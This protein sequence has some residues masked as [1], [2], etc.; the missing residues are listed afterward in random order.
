MLNERIEQTIRH[1]Y[2]SLLLLQEASRS[3]PALKPYLFPLLH[4]VVGHHLKSGD[5]YYLNVPVQEDGAILVFADDEGIQRILAETAALLAL[6]ERPAIPAQL[7]ARKATRESTWSKYFVEPRYREKV[8]A[9]QPFFRALALALIASDA[10]GSALRRTHLPIT[11]W[12]QS[13]FPQAPLTAEELEKTIIKGRIAD[14]ARRESKPFSP[15]HLQVAAQKL[16]SRAVVVSPCGSGKTLAAYMW[17]KKQ[18]ER[19]EARRV[20]FLYPTR[21]TATEGFRDYVSWGLEDS[22]LMHGTSDFDLQGMSFN[23][24][25]PPEGNSRNSGRHR[26][27]FRPE[28]ALYAL[29]YWNRRYISATVDAFLSF[30]A[31]RY[32]ADCVLPLL[33]DSVLVVDEVHALD[34]RMFRHLRRFLEEC[35]LPVL[36]MTAT[37]PPRRRQVFDALGIPVDDGGEEAKHAASRPRYDIELS[38]DQSMDSHLKA[39]LSGD[40]RRLLL[41]RNRVAAC[42]ET[43]QRVQ[44]LIDEIDPSV[45]MLVYHSRF[46]LKDRQQRHEEVIDKFK[47]PER[48]LILVSTQVCQM[49]LDLDAE[50]LFTELAPFPDLVQR[51]G[52]ANRHGRIDRADVVI[53]PPE[54]ARPYDVKDLEEAET[55]LRDLPCPQDTSQLHLAE[56]MDRAGAGDV[57]DQQT[58]PLFDSLPK[59]ESQPYREIQEFTT[60]ALLDCDVQEYLAL[61]KSRRPGLIVPVPRYETK[62]PDNSKLKFLRIASGDKYS[63]KYGYG[64]CDD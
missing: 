21:N 20:I 7:S 59:L 11:E 39:W 63:S 47:G 31:N 42:Q 10:A 50:C 51:M 23:G 32:A 61:D 48:R 18:L 3:S 28:E 45:E 1:E 17:A 38:Q 13:C 64:A 22:A 60:S 35:D 54:K 15:N 41:V 62:P 6:P 30:T 26:A 34:H 49:S 25:E 2:L 40:Q 55:L 12:I 8:E 27:N 33:C 57:A 4:T 36:M 58:V 5:Q 29:G 44:E 56:L 37:L 19:H 24:D 14:I 53:F 9:D 46:R 43:A 52:R 16:P